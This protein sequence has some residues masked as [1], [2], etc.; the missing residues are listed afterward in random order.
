MTIKLN[1]G[2]DFPSATEAKKIVME[3][4]DAGRGRILSSA[5]RIA[6]ECVR[7]LIAKSVN[8]GGET[9][10]GFRICEALAGMNYRGT[11]VLVNEDTVPYAARMLRQEGYAVYRTGRG[12]TLAD[13]ELRDYWSDLYVRL[14]TKD[15]SPLAGDSVSHST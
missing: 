2:L 11:C 15:E 9:L 8:S 13:S 6:K 10:W 1:D 3:Q 7:V 5:R 12:G 14:P 4:L